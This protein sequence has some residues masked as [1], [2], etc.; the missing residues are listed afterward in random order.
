MKVFKDMPAVTR[1]A[2]LEVA[3]GVPPAVEPRR[4]APRKRAKTTSHLQ[5]SKPGGIFRCAIKA[6]QSKS[7]LDRSRIQQEFNRLMLQGTPLCLIS[8]S[9]HGS[10]PLQ[11]NPPI[12]MKKNSPPPHSG[13]PHEVASI[14]HPAFRTPHFGSGGVPAKCANGTRTQKFKVN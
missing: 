12:F 3:A 14:P 1:I 10:G 5:I 2:A 6:N 9:P 4:L 13:P 11:V 7:N 8:S